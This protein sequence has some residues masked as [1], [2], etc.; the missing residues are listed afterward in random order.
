M[1]TK[2][3]RPFDGP[4]VGRGAPL[5]L[6]SPLEWPILPGW[7]GVDSAISFRLSSKRQATLSEQTWEEIMSPIFAADWVINALLYR[8]RIWVVLHQLFIGGLQEFVYWIGILCASRIMMGWLSR[9]SLSA[10]FRRIS[11]EKIP[12]TGMLSGDTRTPSDVF[13]RWE[14]SRRTRS[15]EILLY[16]PGLPHLL[17][18]WICPW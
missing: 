6:N 15:Q 11:L 9:K 5:F 14:E 2:W 3:S 4:V 18:R 12:P 13:Q 8:R 7:T 16:G 1:V 17:N 10:I